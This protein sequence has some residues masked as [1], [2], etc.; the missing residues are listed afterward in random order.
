MNQERLGVIYGVVNLITNNE[1]TGQTVD[2]RNRMNVHRRAK[3]DNPFY[4]AIKKYGTENFAY[5]FHREDVPEWE[6]D[7]LEI[8]YIEKYDTY[9]NG[10]NSSEGG[11]GG[12]KSEETKRKMRESSKGTSPWNKGKSLS[13]KH[14]SNIGKSLKGNRNAVKKKKLNETGQSSFLEC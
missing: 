8:H 6:L 4:Q 7:D 1:Y 9:G 12:Q 14:K 3:D 10:Y 5:Y 2:L 13:E 11:E